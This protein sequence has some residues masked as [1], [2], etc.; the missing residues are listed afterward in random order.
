M[1]YD[2]RLNYTR[3]FNA[4][5]PLYLEA[6]H[7]QLECEEEEEED[8]AADPDHLVLDHLRHEV[9]DHAS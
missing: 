9:P 8:P 4:H 5:A 6:Q 1:L 3:A 7:E 2:A